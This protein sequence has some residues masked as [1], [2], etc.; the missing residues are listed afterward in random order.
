MLHQSTHFVLYEHCRCLAS[1]V[2]RRYYKRTSHLIRA[3]TESEKLHVSK[4]VFIFNYTL[5]AELFNQ[6]TVI[7]KGAFRKICRRE[8]KEAVT[9]NL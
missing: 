7:A 2:I 8:N 3:V 5:P 9:Y 6:C 4:S 1:D